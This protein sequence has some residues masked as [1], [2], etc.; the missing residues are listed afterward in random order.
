MLSQN[1][2][3]SILK[4]STNIRIDV[5][6]TEYY[7]L[8]LHCELPYEFTIDDIDDVYSNGYGEIEVILTE[9]SGKEFMKLSRR[10]NMFAPNGWKEHIAGSGNMHLTINTPT[11]WDFYQVAVEEWHDGKLEVKL[12]AI[13]EDMECYEVDHEV[14]QWE[15]DNV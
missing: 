3:R 9:N 14:S 5:R 1:G 12:R 13:H 8:G 11:D 7:E 6:C 15:E 10:D 2:N 4:M